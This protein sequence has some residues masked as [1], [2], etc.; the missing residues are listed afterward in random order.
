ME[1]WGPE[2]PDLDGGQELRV[3]AMRNLRIRQAD[4]FVDWVRRRCNGVRFSGRGPRGTRYGRIWGGPGRRIGFF[5]SGREIG[6]EN[7]VDGAT[8]VRYRRP[9]VMQALRTE[10]FAESS[11]ERAVRVQREA[12][13]IQQA[14]SQIEAG[15]G[16]DDDKLEA[17]LDSLDHDPSAPLPTTAKP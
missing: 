10:I 15:E 16:I 17:W 1:R 5:R 7:G 13:V 3:D 12:A 9:M 14:R 4:D 8:A 11:A 6:A 2:T